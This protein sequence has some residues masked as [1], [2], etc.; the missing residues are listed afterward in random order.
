MSHYTENILEAPLDELV[1][2]CSGVSK[3][4]ILD[5]IRNGARDMDDIR[6]MTGACTQG[7]CKDI[8]PRSRCCSNEIKILLAAEIIK[9]KGAVMSK[10]TS[11][12]IMVFVFGY[13]SLSFAITT[14]EQKAVIKAATVFLDSTPDNN[15][16]IQPEEIN[17]LLQSGSKSFL[18]VDVRSYKEF[19]GGHLPGAINIPYRDIVDP[20]N[21]ALFPR[22]KE[23][24]LY[25]N[26]GHESTK[27]LSVLRML[28]YNVYGMKWGMM[29]W[30]VVPSTSAALKAIAAGTTGNY[31]LV[32]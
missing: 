21:L 14:D 32:K 1:C 17:K 15:F 9:T 7:R 18:L 25:C 16:F 8:S 6:R 12:L 13:Y 22:D 11:I 3:R 19:K 10:A 30:N 26:S 24:I 2:W 23:I 28:G 27:V 31:P 5:A 29:G 20:N 4:S